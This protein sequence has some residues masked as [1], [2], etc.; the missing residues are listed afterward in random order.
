VARYK[1]VMIDRPA[2]YQPI[3]EQEEL[4]PIDAEVLVGWA[5]LGQPRDLDPVMAS[6][7]LSVE[8]LSKISISYVASG[9]HTAEVM[10]Q[11]AG[12]ADAIV[13]TSAKVTAAVMDRLPSLRVIGRPGIG[14]DVIDVP[15]ATERGIAVFSAPGFCAREVAD[16]TMMFA[17]ACARKAPMLHSAIRRGVYE[18]GLSAPLAACYEMTLG[19]IAFGE[20]A[21]E[22]AAR[23]KPFGFRI[24]ASDPYVDQATADK[25]GVELVG[26]DELLQRS[27]LVS[28]HAPLSDGTFHLLSAKEFALMKPTAYVINTARGGLIDQQALITAL[29]A[30]QIAG[31]ALDV[32]E[33]EPL[34]PDSPLAK[35]ENVFLTP[36]TAGVSD[37]SQIETRRRTSRNIANALVG[38]WPETR[39]LVNPE[40]K[41]RGRQASI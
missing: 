26:L 34:E 16:H 1:V 18:R 32:F 22:V 19:L 21:R 24:L 6:T 7:G 41:G 13:V 9:K 35:M 40:V 5:R 28:V 2:W 4:S 33:R 11:M 39:D 17:L 31:A 30:G 25:Y 15:A 38:E 27:D 14:Y 12:D 37:S 20:I 23:A 36:H 29:E 3:I 8:E 10:E